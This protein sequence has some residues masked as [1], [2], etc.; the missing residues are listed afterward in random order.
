M[1][2]SAQMIVCSGS[3]GAPYDGAHHVGPSEGFTVIEPGGTVR[4]FCDGDYLR[5][6]YR[7]RWEAFLAEL[8]RER[9][10]MGLR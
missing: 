4:Q 10:G 1:I 7:H 6:H 3:H 5:G 8:G 9:E 2:G